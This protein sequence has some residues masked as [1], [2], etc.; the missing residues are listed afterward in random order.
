MA[1][2]LASTSRL[3]VAK[4]RRHPVWSSVHKRPQRPEFLVKTFH[5]YA[6]YGFVVE[7]DEPMQSL[8]PATDSEGDPAITV[9]FVAP[10]QLRSIAPDSVP[11]VEA[12][13]WVGHALR[14]D[15]SIHLKADEIFEAIVSSDGRTVTCASL[16]SV[17]RRTLEANL[18]N[19]VLATSLTLRGEEPLHSTVVDFGGQAIGLLGP[20]GAGKSTLAAY[21]VSRGADL[22][23][24][25][26]LRVDFSGGSPA[27]H[28]GP[29]RLKLL[30][31]P[32]RRLLPGALADG[33]FNELNGKTMVRPRAEG[34]QRAAAVPLA[35]LYYI[36]PHEA[37]PEPRTV[38]AVRLTG[39]ELA[40][41][42]LSSTLHDL[43]RP[44]GRLARQ[45]EFAA[46]MARSL[47]I[48]ALRY[49]RTF[50]A[51]DEVAAEIRRTAGS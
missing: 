18:M 51:M 28:H 12:G 10:H 46:R 34:R 1:A 21:L 49:P 11:K 4:H 8:R 9:R 15:G 47:P 29:Y 2:S 25:D 45:L 40:R 32:G 30:E 5:R 48:Y 16:G 33:H 26:I 6:V 42:I 36:G 24:D 31:E 44:P 50:D 13:H 27:A 20:S 17:D 43:Y 19:I 39:L 22:V 35:G 38:S 7:I 23:T 41:V 37:Q 14:T 3:E